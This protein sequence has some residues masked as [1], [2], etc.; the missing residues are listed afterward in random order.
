MSRTARLATFMSSGKKLALVLNPR[1]NRESHDPK[2][3]QHVA[4]YQKGSMIW[5]HGGVIRRMHNRLGMRANKTDL[6]DATRLQDLFEVFEHA[7]PILRID[8][9]HKKA[10]TDEIKCGVPVFR[11]RVKYVPD[12]KVE[13]TAVDGEHL[14]ADV[15]PCDMLDAG[16]LVAHIDEPGS[17]ATA[18]VQDSG[19][20]LFDEILGLRND[21]P[22]NTSCRNLVLLVQALALIVIT[23]KQIS[24]FLGHLWL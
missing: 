9:Q 16:V 17:A 22:A 18:H 19:K 2:K 15:E 3:E 24:L 11:K 1:I 21:Q 13:A 6:N 20:R 12:A 10:G 23:A 5:V 14:V 7:I 4:I 8:P